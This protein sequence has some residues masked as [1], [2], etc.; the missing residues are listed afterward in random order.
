MDMEIVNVLDCY[1]DNEQVKAICAP[2][3]VKDILDPVRIVRQIHFHNYNNTWSL[4]VECTAN[5]WD[6][7]DDEFAEWLNE[8]YGDSECLRYIEKEGENF[9]PFYIFYFVLGK[10]IKRVNI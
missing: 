6:W 3:E 2:N 10:I 7:V 4:D 1:K 9:K 5:D 8:E